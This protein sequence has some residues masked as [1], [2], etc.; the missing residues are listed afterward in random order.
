MKNL[1]GIGREELIKRSSLVCIF[2]AVTSNIS[3][4]KKICTVLVEN[5]DRANI[6]PPPPI[7]QILWISKRRVTLNL[8]RSTSWRMEYVFKGF[9]FFSKKLRI[10]SQTKKIIQK[11]KKKNFCNL[12]HQNHIN[13]SH[14]IRQKYVFFFDIKL[15]FF[16]F[17][18]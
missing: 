18:I 16:I 11:F 10:F 13:K 15:S 1:W 8:S 5:G 17:M 3:F 6:S 4:F 14:I 2:W 12:E 9:H 7:S